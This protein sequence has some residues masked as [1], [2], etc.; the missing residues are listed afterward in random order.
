MRSPQCE[1]CDIYCQ[2]GFYTVRVATDGTIMLCP[3]Y[4]AK[5]PHI[6]SIESI[7]NGTMKKQLKQLLNTFAETVP[8]Q[9]LLRFFDKYDINP[10]SPL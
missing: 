3:D 6:N 9:S 2:E 4:R 10:N 5:L 7:E 1:T 8:T